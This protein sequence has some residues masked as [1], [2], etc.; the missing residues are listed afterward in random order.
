MR[1]TVVDDD[2]YMRD[3]IPQIIGERLRNSHYWNI[4]KHGRFTPEAVNYIFHDGF[5]MPENPFQ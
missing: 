1:F 3:A 4:N 5:P 2:E